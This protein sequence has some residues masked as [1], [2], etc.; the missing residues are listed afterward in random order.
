MDND[1][2]RDYDEE[3][4]NRALMHDEAEIVV[5][6][7]ESTRCEHCDG[8]IRYVD[9]LLGGAWQHIVTMSIYCAADGERVASPTRHRDLRTSSEMIR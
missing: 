1:D 8:R 4:Y 6:P 2:E 7:N 9:A 3:A 5:Y